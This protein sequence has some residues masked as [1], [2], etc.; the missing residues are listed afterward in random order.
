[1]RFLC[2]I[3]IKGESVDHAEAFI[4]HFINFVV[5]G[6]FLAPTLKHDNEVK[7]LIFFSFFVNFVSFVV[8]KA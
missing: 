5:I 6:L 3:A 1:M 2:K 8:K 4:G 7:K